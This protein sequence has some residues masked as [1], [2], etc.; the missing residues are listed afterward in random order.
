MLKE[1]N[2]IAWRSKGNKG[3][4][5]GFVREISGKMLK[6]ADDRFETGQWLNSEEIEIEPLNKEN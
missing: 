3:Y 4:C 5:E 2:R 1:N 6:I